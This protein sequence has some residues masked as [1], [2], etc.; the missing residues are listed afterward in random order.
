LQNN[1]LIFANEATDSSTM[2]MPSSHRN[3]STW[4]SNPM[5][6]DDLYSHSTASCSEGDPLHIS[7]DG[8]THKS[9]RQSQE[10]APKRPPRGSRRASLGG[11]T[12]YKTPD[13]AKLDACLRS[14]G[15]RLKPDGT[16]QF[17]FETTR[18]IIE[19]TTDVEEA[20]EFLLYCSLGELRD[21]RQ[22]FG[23][24]QRKLLKMLALWNEE[25]QMEGGDDTG[26]LRIDSSKEDGPHVS[27]IYYGHVKNIEGPDDFQEL[28]DE[29]VDDGLDFF[30]RLNNGDVEEDMVPAQR[31]PRNGS[32]SKN[33]ESRRVS[34]TKSLKSH[35]TATTVDTLSSEESAVIRNQAKGGS[36]HRTSPPPPPQHAAP[37]A[38][39]EFGSSSTSLSTS[40]EK[41]GK[42]SV[43]SKVIST[44]QKKNDPTVA[45]AF[46]DPSNPTS[47]FVVDKTVANSEECV[48]PKIVI[49]RKGAEKKGASFHVEGRDPTRQQPT[50]TAKSFHDDRSSRIVKRSSLPDVQ[51][52]G[53]R[54]SMISKRS[55]QPSVGEDSDMSYGM[56]SASF[57]DTRR[58]S[59]L[60][61]SGR[62]T[63]S[64]HHTSKSRRT[65]IEID[66]VNDRYESRTGHN[67]SL[68]RSVD[69]F[70][71]SGPIE[72]QANKPTSFNYSEPVLPSHH[73][74]S[75]R[76]TRTRPVDVQSDKHRL[77]RSNRS[78]SSNHSR[79][80]TVANDTE[81]PRTIDKH[82]RDAMP[83]EAKAL[84][85]YYE[86]HNAYPPPPPPRNSKWCMENDSHSDCESDEFS[87]ED[88]GL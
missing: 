85:S 87:L 50:R 81:R 48:K 45:M 17:L 63:K 56:K 31:S 34:S 26:L 62:K 43:F 4:T 38:A 36:F 14:S 77:D 41:N 49:S 27:F 73:V 44:L 59:M 22:N 78:Q 57:Y 76:S 21:L 40:Q 47:A 9:R 70:N 24:S 58:F 33:H 74:K 11:T 23:G 6:E 3:G 86:R 79:R 37:P 71:D 53:R 5:Q 2:T 55:S 32:I 69:I 18:F 84:K 28:L 82:R 60:D 25:L 46:I 39:S 80:K 68:N 1:L 65:S 64:F 72:V 51:E 12:I 10:S 67:L 8:P 20:G 75:K 7:D 29:F 35:S 15:L 13:M 30:D 42:K 66:G 88:E 54:G 61:E 16:C 83:Y 19:T 52:D